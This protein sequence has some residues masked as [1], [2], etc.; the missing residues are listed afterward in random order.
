MTDK[1]DKGRDYD[2]LYGKPDTPITLNQNLIEKNNIS[3]QAQ[4][5]M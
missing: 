3:Q 4:D 5:K 1:Y 2:N